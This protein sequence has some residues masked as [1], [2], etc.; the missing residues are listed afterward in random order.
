MGSNRDLRDLD[1]SIPYGGYEYVEMVFNA[2]A[3]G[4]TEIPYDTLTPGDP[5][6]VDWQVVGV[7]FA[8]APAAAPVVYRDESATRRPWRTNYIVLRSNVASLRATLL[9]STRRHP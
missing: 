7:K 4:D 8:S 6:Q 5:E 9:L 3:N 1:N 2:N